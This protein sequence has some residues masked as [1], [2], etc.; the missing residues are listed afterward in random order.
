MGTLA[1]DLEPVIKQVGP[2]SSPNCCSRAA[3]LPNTQ[4]VQCWR[5]LRSPNKDRKCAHGKYREKVMIRFGRDV[6]DNLNE[7]LRREWLETNGLGGFASSTIIGLNTG[8]DHGLAVGRPQTAGR[9]YLH[10]SK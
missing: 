3:S 9:R 2:V 10:L 8:R 6:C 4:G 5:P 1:R 7:A